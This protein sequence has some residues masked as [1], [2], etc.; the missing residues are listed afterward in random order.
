MLYF[1]W[2]NG[3]TENAN[4]IES[5]PELFFDNYKG[6]LKRGANTYFIK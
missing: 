3:K 4:Y 5:L 1:L 2:S 6:V